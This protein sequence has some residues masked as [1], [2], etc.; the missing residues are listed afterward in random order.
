MK[1]EIRKYET[2]NTE[3]RN[4]KY[5]NTK[6]EIRNWSEAELGG[7]KYKFRMTV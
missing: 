4:T 6:H 1:Y 7:D 2:R 3:I 5:G